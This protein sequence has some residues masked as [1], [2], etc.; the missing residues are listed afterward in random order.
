M[1]IRVICR[2]LVINL[3]GVYNAIEVSLRIIAAV[4]VLAN[5]FSLRISGFYS[6]AMP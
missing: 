4:G 1:R 5:S 3:N 6:I 2:R